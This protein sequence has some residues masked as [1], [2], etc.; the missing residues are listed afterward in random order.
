[1]TKTILQLLALV[2][3]VLATTTG[4]MAQNSQ[5]IVTHG[6]PGT[7]AD[8]TANQ[9]VLS[10]LA[11]L[12]EADTLI[13]INPQRLLNEAAPRLMPEKDLAEMRKSFNDMR[14]FV[15]VDPS[16]LD[17]VVI[18]VRFRKPT[19]ELSFQP[20]EFIALASGDFSADS[21]VALAGVHSGGQLRNE[22]YGAKTLGL[23]T[24]DPIAKEA[25][26]NPMLKAF[27]EMGIVPLNAT[28]IAVGT[29]AYLKAA[30]DASE[31]TGRISSESLNS[32][33]RDPAA[34]ISIAG[35]PLSSF[36][37]SFGLLGTEANARAARCDSRFG[38]FYAA[39]TMEASNFTLRGALNADNPDTARIIN[40]LIGGLVQ[41]ATS[42]VP[43][44]TAQAA[45]KGLSITAQEHEVILR[46]DVPRQMVLDFIKQQIGPKKEE[47][48]TATPKP[49]ARK[50]A[51]RRRKRG[52]Q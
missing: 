15:G 21:L 14:Q 22:K 5:V 52:R 32:L 23:M 24:I 42:S 41:Q 17:Y 45:L 20:P 25:E 29:T 11:S 13:F 47:S 46:A 10:S 1:M 27:S 34:L 26:K 43:D 37:K 36:S 35:S 9:T 4:L 40:S 48:A 3:L 38:D 33:L 2:L 8:S 51:T 7:V 12:P 28:T 19:A 31:G 16:K 30:V 50:P 18:A 6:A 44:K 49:T 39:I